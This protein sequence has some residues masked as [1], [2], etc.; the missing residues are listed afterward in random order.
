MADGVGKGILTSGFKGATAGAKLGT[1]IN[2]GIGTIIGGIGGA[3]AG[4]TIGGVNAKR[5]KD[6]REKGLQLPGLEDP[7]QTAR[8]LE[9]DRMAKNIQAGSDAATQIALDEGR[10]T[11]AAAQ[12]RI[13]RVTGGSPGATVDALLKSQ[14]AGQ[15][16]GNQAI[17][18]GQTQLPFFQNLGN[19]LATRAEQRKLELQLLDRAQTSAETAQSGKERNVNSNALMASGLLGSNINADRVKSLVNQ[20]LGKLGGD[21][22]GM[23]PTEMTPI[24]NGIGGGEPPAFPGLDGVGGIGGGAGLGG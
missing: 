9:V 18:Q 19:Q 24:D 22:Q 1:K 20:G 17:A 5:D 4:G 2:P 23:G 3:I 14:R 15:Q 12:S 13:S 21:V 8:R 16:A 7:L 6:K 10:G 11:T